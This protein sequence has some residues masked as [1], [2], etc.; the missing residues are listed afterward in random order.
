MLIMKVDTL[1]QKVLFQR[2]RSAPDRVRNALATA[3]EKIGRGV[4]RSA[5][6]WLSGSRA[7]TG[8]FPVPVRTGHLRRMLDWLAPGQ[9]RSAGGSTITAG[10]L[11]SVVY[12]TAAYAESIAKGGG[13]SAKFGDRD[14]LAQALEEFNAGDG[15][16]R[17]IDDE[18][19]R[20]LA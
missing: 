4:F 8:G 20:E 6:D 19:E 10:P 9:S 2:L 14:F 3:M 15:I 13:S 1:N 11:E 17:A 18:L 16:A 5:F 12:N 7:D